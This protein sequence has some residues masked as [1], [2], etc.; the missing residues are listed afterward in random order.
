[1]S[2]LETYNLPIEF[3]CSGDLRYIESMIVTMTNEWIGDNMTFT[4]DDQMQTQMC[5]FYQTSGTVLNAF[6]D[7]QQGLFS[8]NVVMTK[9]F[10]ADRKPAACVA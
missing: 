4:Y 10:L 6:Y 2:S 3:K 1:M 9:L 8:C 7:N 5:T